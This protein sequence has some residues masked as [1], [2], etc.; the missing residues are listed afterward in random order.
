MPSE[1]TEASAEGQMA[2]L[3]VCDGPA[4]DT[5]AKKKAEANKKKRERQKA[6]KAAE[7]V[8]EEAGV[9]RWHKGKLPGGRAERCDAGGNRGLGVFTLEDMPKGS[10]IASAPPALSCVFDPFVSSVCSFCFAQPA[11]G[12]VT[13]QQVSLTTSAPDESNNRTFGI[14][15]DDYT[16]PGANAPVAIV[17][18]ITKESPNRETV[19]VGDRLIAVDGTAVGGGQGKAVALLLE[20]IKKGGAVSC[21]IAR[22]ALVFCEGCKKV[23]CCEK[24]VG[25]GRL[26]WHAYECHMLRNMPPQVLSGE[27][28]IVRMLLRYTVS[29]DERIGEWGD[30]KEPVEILT[31]L[32]ANAC[33]VPPEQLSMLS[34]V[35]TV[36]ASNVAKLIFQVRTNAC[37]VVRGGERV[38]SALSVLM[39]WHNHDCTPNAHAVVDSDG[40]V[41]IRAIRDL[42]RGDEVTISYVDI[43]EPYQERRKTL[44]SHYGFECV[45][46]RCTTEQRQELK[47]RMKERDAYLAGQRR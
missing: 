29:T 25:K 10:V 14:K 9:T 27:S 19:R 30:D 22:P 24:C 45:C 36:S 15:L 39:G 35:T 32:Q 46:Q 12:K 33:N 34:K 42:K 5:A 23:A 18:M 47:S 41:V 1:A 7:K 40:S 20:A 44:Q 17:T 11:E 4:A 21:T 37:E 3:D 28:S 43:R 26:K 13:E 31:S 16:P 38:G 8:A 2:A 6:K